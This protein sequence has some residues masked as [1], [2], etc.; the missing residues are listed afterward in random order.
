MNVQDNVKDYYGKVLTSSEDLQT[1]ACCTI[2]DMPDYLKALLANIH[3]DVRARYYGCGLIA[4]LA[5]VGVLS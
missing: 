3:P 4:P 2:A 5:L 1:D